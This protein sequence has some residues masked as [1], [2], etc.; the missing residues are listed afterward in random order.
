MF[1][2]LIAGE[3][4][5]ENVLGL[6]QFLGNVLSLT[7]AENQ[8]FEMAVNKGRLHTW[9]HLHGH[10]F[11]LLLPTESALNIFSTPFH[12]FIYEGWNFNSGNYLFTTDTK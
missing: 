8:D 1:V 10:S 7:T 5:L 12:N 9:C 3:M 2:L 11:L 6:K 4:W